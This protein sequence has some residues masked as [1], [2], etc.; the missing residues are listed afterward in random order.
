VR[1]CTCAYTCVVYTYCSVLIVCSTWKRTSF[2]VYGLCVYVCA[3]VYMGVGVGVGVGGTAARIDPPSM[4]VG[5]VCMCA[6][7][8]VLV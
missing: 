4:H 1:V 8:C 7:A 6:H 5:C 2:Y 3:H